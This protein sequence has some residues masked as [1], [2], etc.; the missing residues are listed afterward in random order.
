VLP[1]L[2]LSFLLGCA[3]SPAGGGS[4]EVYMF[5]L[6]GGFFFGPGPIVPDTSLPDGR[7]S[8]VHFDRAHFR[9]FAEFRNDDSAQ[10]KLSNGR[11][12]INQNI[13]AG[14]LMIGGG[15]SPIML[16]AVDG[17]PHS[18]REIYYLDTDYRFVWR[19]DLALDPGF[20]EGIIRIDDF[21]LHTGVVRI[22]PSLQ[23]KGGLP[24][25]YDQ[26]GTLSTGRYLVGRVGDFDQDGFLDGVL[27][28]APNVPLGSDMLPGAPVGNRRGF[29]TNIPIAPHL[30]AELVLRSLR[31]LRQP[32][33]E[34]VAR[35]DAADYLALMR[36]VSEQLGA[37]SA[38]LQHA[39]AGQAGLAPV[40]EAARRL[41]AL[42]LNHAGAGQ[43]SDEQSAAR[44]PIPQDAS[45]AVHALFQEVDAVIESL[46]SLN[47]QAGLNLS[48]ATIADPPG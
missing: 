20:D 14:R 48:R 8:N 19:V 18:G 11:T 2:L 22:A 33:A 30:S 38:N 35:N 1:A 4:D 45:A 27:V 29:K 5:Q 13:E 9:G 6:T 7:I 25:G 15:T 16:T 47:A 46:A 23:T 42:P 37:A 28:A 32:L 24:G 44:P 17:G 21:V 36:E 40:R 34:T 39:S 31:H 12:R 41:A 3:A 26:A 10:S 43:R